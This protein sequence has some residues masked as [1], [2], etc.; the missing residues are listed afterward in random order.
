MPV[1]FFLNLPVNRMSTKADKMVTLSVDPSEDD[2]LVITLKRE[3]SDI[4]I[5]GNEILVGKR[6]FLLKLTERTYIQAVRL[7]ILLRS[8]SL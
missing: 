4:V 5:R 2:D 1:E 3:L 8:Y 7:G 6:R